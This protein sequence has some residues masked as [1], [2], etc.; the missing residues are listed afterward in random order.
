MALV[1]RRRF[2]GLVGLVAAEGILHKGWA[3]GHGAEHAAPAKPVKIS[4]TTKLYNVFLNIV[5]IS[6]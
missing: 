4:K 6:C 5:I 2:A 3:Q 1:S